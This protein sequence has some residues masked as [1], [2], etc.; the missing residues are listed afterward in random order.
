M[1]NFLEKYKICLIV[2]NDFFDKIFGFLSPVIFVVFITVVTILCIR[3]LFYIFLSVMSRFYLINKKKMKRMRMQPK[4]NLTTYKKETEELFREEKIERMQNEAFNMV[5]IDNINR[6][7]EEKISVVDDTRIV[8]IVKPVGFWTS[9]ILGDGLSKIL[10]KAH[11]LNKR[12]GKGFWISMLE[13]R[14]RSI[15][16]DR[17]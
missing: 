1:S 14:S 17:Y 15:G 4:S 3:F 13:T 6:D 10:G 12:S 11:A 8:G 2:K 16:Q 7:F 9:L 5:G